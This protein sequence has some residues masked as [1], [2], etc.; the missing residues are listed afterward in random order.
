MS[1]SSS[2]ETKENQQVQYELRISRSMDCISE[3]SKSVKTAVNNHHN[4]L[5]PFN[6]QNPSFT[7]PLTVEELDSKRIIRDSFLNL[8]LIVN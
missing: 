5:K 4:H 6:L 8:N 7:P 2:K 3:S 1:Q